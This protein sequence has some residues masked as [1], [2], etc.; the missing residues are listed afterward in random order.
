MKNPKEWVLGIDPGFNNT[1]AVL[2]L[3]GEDTLE[4]ACWSNNNTNDW[5]VLRAMSIC[6]P[7]METVLAWLHKHNITELKICLEDPVYNSNA[8]T[9]MV[10]MVLYTMIQ[11]YIYDYLVPVL[12][13]VYLTY[14]NNK[15]SKKRMTGDGNAS[16]EAM[17]AASHWV[18]RKDMTYNQ[19]HTL[20]DAYAHSLGHSKDGLALHRMPQYSVEANY[21]ESD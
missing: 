7:M 4:A 6:I 3:T 18:G 17:I 8:K 13:K 2:R 14:V 16:K 11:T 9:F 20:A 21:D 5:E 1:G 10:Q 19:R 15:S 12:D